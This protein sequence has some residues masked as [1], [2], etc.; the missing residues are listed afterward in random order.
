MRHIDANTVKKTQCNYLNEAKTET[1][2]LNG[3]A[4]WRET[5]VGKSDASTKK[6]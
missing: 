5:V 6:H 4:L 3:S 1:P 2:G